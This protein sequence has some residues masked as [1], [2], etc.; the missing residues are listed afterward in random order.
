MSA[1]PRLYALLVGI[2]NY[3]I[4]PLKGC[5]NDVENVETYLK[6]KTTSNCAIEKVLNED[7]T[8]SMFK[9]VSRRECQ[10]GKGVKKGNWS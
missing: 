2:N 3:N 8:K 10:I 6:H 4:K 1:S 5:V 9:E 7:A